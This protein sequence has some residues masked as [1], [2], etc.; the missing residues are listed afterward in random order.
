MTDVTLVPV[1]E[2]EPEVAR[3]EAA[4]EAGGPLD[5]LKYYTEER[6]KLAKL[7]LWSSGLALLLAVVSR[8]PTWQVGSPVAWLIGSVNVGFVPI[9]APIVIFGLFCHVILARSRVRELRD[10]LATDGKLESP[11]ARAAL[12]ED[13]GGGG[14]ARVAETVFE[15]WLL[16]VPIVAYA[17]LICTYFDFV[18]PD[19]HGG[20]YAK[21]RP[22]EIA[23]LLLGTGGWSGFRPSTPSIHDN[24]LRLAAKSE[25]NERAKLETIADQMPW[26]YPP[27]QTWAYLGG[28]IFMIWLARAN[29]RQ[30]RNR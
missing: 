21:T 20:R 1:V 6:E 28:W 8:L 30:R 10:A 27:Y 13:R 24:L 18:R 19:G 4:P 2:E 14:A 12:G 9:F 15:I 7:S 26:I 11:F 29:L 17:I 23:D 3:A 5:R 25:P 22:A 16:A